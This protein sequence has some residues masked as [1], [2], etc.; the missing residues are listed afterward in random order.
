MKFSN[1]GHSPP[2]MFRVMNII[3]GMDALLMGALDHLEST[4]EQIS[5]S[6]RN[7]DIARSA[8][9]LGTRVPALISVFLT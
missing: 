6:I 1:L 3:S 4:P 8:K 2:A 9:L 5:A 7:T